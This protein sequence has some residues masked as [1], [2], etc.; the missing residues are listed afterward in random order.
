MADKTYRKIVATILVEA[1][2]WAVLVGLASVV[3]ERVFGVKPFWLLLPLSCLAADLGMYAARQVR[4]EWFSVANAP[5][6]RW[7]IQQLATW[8]LLAVVIRVLVWR[9]VRE[10]EGRPGTWRPFRYDILPL[11]FAPFGPVLLHPLGD[12][13]PLG[14]G[15]R[16]ATAALLG[17]PAGHPFRRDRRAVGRLHDVYR[18]HAQ[19]G[20]GPLQRGDFPLQFGQ[21]G[22]RAN[23]RQFLEIDALRLLHRGQ[24]LPGTGQPHTAV[25]T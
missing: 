5:F 15:H 13:L 11:L 19:A 12:N 14:A 1:G 20:K 3:W 25:P 18:Q 16:L 10:R 17:H 6:P 24:P 4:S 2:G 8:T 7:L 23:P 9:L 21:P 22:G